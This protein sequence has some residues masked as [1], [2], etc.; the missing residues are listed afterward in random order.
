MTAFLRSEDGNAP[1]GQRQFDVFVNVEIANQVK[2][3]ENEADLRLRM[4]ARSCIF[5][6]TTGCLF[7]VYWPSLAV[8]SRPRIASS[9]DLPQPE[10]RDRHVLA[11]IDMR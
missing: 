8:S 2:C 3:L 10:G 4:R 9:V 7:S 6:L 11:A 5:R 1:V